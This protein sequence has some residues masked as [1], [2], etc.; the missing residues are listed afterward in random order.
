MSRLYDLPQ[1]GPL[2]VQV[3]L[4]TQR[5]HTEDTQGV[6]NHSSTEMCQSV[7]LPQVAHTT[8]P[9]WMTEVYETGSLT[10]VVDPGRRRILLTSSWIIYS[11]E[12]CVK[13]E[14]YS[15]VPSHRS[16]NYPSTRVAFGWGIS[17]S[18]VLIHHAFPANTK[19]STRV[20]KTLY[21]NITLPYKIPMSK[22]TLLPNEVHK[23]AVRFNT[24][25][26][27]QITDTGLY[28]G[29]WSPLSRGDIKIIQLWQRAFKCTYKKPKWIASRLIE[30]MRFTHPRSIWYWRRT[31][32]RRLHPYDAGIIINLHSCNIVHEISHSHCS[33]VRQGPTIHPTSLRQEFA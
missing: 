5:D 27:K 13:S 12:S 28:P 2:L 33:D 29:K 14:T 22:T 31:I 32:L 15:I 25:W 7:W 17:L 23:E 11:G 21:Q 1:Y 16:G 18:R 26:Q 8:T 9:W 24:T 30:G 20:I 3:I 4:E 19:P 6:S 10:R